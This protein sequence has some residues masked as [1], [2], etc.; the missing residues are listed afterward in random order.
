MARRLG[1]KTGPALKRWSPLRR[2][3]KRQNPRHSRDPL[4]GARGTRTPDLLGAIQACASPESALFA[5]FSRRRRPGL[6]SA[7]S[8]HFRS[9]RLGSGQ[10]NGSLARSPVRPATPAGLAALSTNRGETTEPVSAW[11]YTLLLRP[12]RQSLTS[13]TDASHPQASPSTTAR[14]SHVFGR[15]LWGAEQLRAGEIPSP[16]LVSLGGPA[17]FADEQMPQV[18]VVDRP[19]D[20]GRLVD[21]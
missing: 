2:P 18:G 15:C 14:S 13:G 8:A 10:R 20:V 4:S 3:A 7:F 16:L 12:F 21:V 9:F 6:R 1:Q 11:A 19:E 5:G 17:T